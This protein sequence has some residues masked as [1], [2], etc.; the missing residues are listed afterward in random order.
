MKSFLP[1]LFFDPN[2]TMR[3][4]FA[5]LRRQ[6]DD[7][8]ASFGREWPFPT[9]VGAGAPALNVSETDKAIEIEAELPGVDEK[10]IKVEIEGQRVIISGEKKRESEEEEKDWRVVERSYGS[11]RRAVTLPFEPAGDAASAHCDKGVLHI[12][13]M[14]PAGARATSRIVE[15]KTGPLEGGRDVSQDKAA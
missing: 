8:A 11:F 9:Q 14:K 15:I 2:V 5:S 7:L 4:P 10:D 1:N 13:I 12:E 3:D 6:I